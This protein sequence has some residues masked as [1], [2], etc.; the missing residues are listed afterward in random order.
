MKWCLED[1]MCENEE[2]S[3]LEG[4]KKQKAGKFGL[5]SEYEKI[6]RRK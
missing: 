4:K 6:C 2:G 5:R 3:I 1:R